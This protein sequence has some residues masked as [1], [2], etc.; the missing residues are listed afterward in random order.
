MMLSYPGIFKN[1]PHV[2][3]LRLYS[4]TESKYVKE[5]DWQRQSKQ[6]RHIKQRR[7]RTRGEEQG[8]ASKAKKI[9]SK[10]GKQ[11]KLIEAV[12]EQA[13]EVEQG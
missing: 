3:F 10:E 12:R 6:S 1:I 7:Q 5:A 2:W 11:S 8:S 13:M 4:L 9:E